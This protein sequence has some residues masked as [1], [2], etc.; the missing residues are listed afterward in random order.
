MCFKIDEK[1]DEIMDEQKVLLNPDRIIDP[2]L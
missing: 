2:D 1:T